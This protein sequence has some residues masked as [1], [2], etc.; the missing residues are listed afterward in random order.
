MNFGEE[1]GYWYLRLNGFFVLNNFV[2]HN[3]VLSQ[4]PEVTSK[5][6]ADVDLLALR[7]PMVSEVIGSIKP[8]NCHWDDLFSEFFEDETGF[9]NTSVALIVEVKT[10]RI[11]DQ[12]HFA[13]DRIEKSLSRLGLCKDSAELRSTATKLKNAKS[14]KLRDW[15]VAKLLIHS[16]TKGGADKNTYKLPLSKCCLYIDSRMKYKSKSSSFLLPST[17]IQF[18]SFFDDE[19][20]LDFSSQIKRKRRDF[21]IGHESL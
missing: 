1:L 18:W 17:L 16:D 13:N 12:R 14:I 7:L 6:T 8:Q 21:D 3:N 4:N 11:D 20:K 5:S 2:M 19:F 9:W 15:T 10:G